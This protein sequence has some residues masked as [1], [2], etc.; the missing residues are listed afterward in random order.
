M[1]LLSKLLSYGTLNSLASA[2]AAVDTDLAAATGYAVGAPAGSVDLLVER[3]AGEET[4]ANAPV[5]TLNATGAADGDTLTQKIYGIADSGPPQL[6]MSI[7]WT[8][9]TARAD[10]ATATFLWA[11]TAVVT[12]THATT[13]VVADGGG[14]NRVCSVFFDVTGYRHLK[15]YITA[16]TGDPVL[17][18]SNYRVY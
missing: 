9:G 17:I 8:I 12:S 7:V 16:Q 11:D 4:Y 18:T 6:I 2:T 10:G 1:A 13:I 14:S 3:G 5:L 15:G